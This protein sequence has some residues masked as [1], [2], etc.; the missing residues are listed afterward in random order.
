M[1]T[2]S[3]C[4]DMREVWM[5]MGGQFRTAIVAALVAIAG[6]ASEVRAAQCGSTA[7]GFEAWKKQFADESKG[8]F[9]AS[10]IAGLMS[11]SYSNAAIAADRGQRSFGLTLEQFMAKRGG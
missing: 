2:A 6:M 10:A 4:R 8:R 3:A 11:T 9:G 1:R 7:A 5:T